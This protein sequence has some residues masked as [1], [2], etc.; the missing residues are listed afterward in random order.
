MAVTNAQRARAAQD[1]AEKIRL[2]NEFIPQLT[3]LFNRVGDDFYQSMLN[4]GV[5]PA[6]ITWQSFFES[7]LLSHYQ[8]VGNVFSRRL[9]DQL[10]IVLSDEE[11]DEINAALALF[12]SNM[13]IDAATQITETNERQA[14]ESITR[15][16]AQED[17]DMD[18][19]GQPYDQ[20]TRANVAGNIFGALTLGR[21]TTI[22][23]TETQTPAEAAKITEADVVAGRQPV[24]ILTVIPVIPP[25]EK[26][27]DTKA[28]ISRRDDRVRPTHVKADGQEVA[29][30]EF[31]IVGGFKMMM[32]GDRSAP[33]EEWVNCRCGVIYNPDPDDLVWR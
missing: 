11:N 4:Q 12:Y 25:E 14:L 23:I 31:F 24:I 27:K 8:A 15:T 2:E 33:M 26:K 21:V 32:P 10:D 22:A 17:A 13:A 5:P 7:L 3:D 6:M 30:D 1:L 29:T 28:W 18:E 16:N 9:R 20:A 19:T